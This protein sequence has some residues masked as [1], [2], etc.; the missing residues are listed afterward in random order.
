M[1]KKQNDPVGDALKN[2]LFLFREHGFDI[3]NSNYQSLKQ[4]IAINEQERKVLSLLK[5][6]F[7]SS[8][9]GSGPTELD[10]EIS[11]LNELITGK[12]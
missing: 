4:A 6:Y 1:S 7:Y 12:K 9:T 8:W 3:W 5:D 10:L 11:K 2:A